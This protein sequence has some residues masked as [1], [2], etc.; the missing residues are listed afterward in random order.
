MAAHGRMDRRGSIMATADGLVDKS[1]RLAEGET[2][3]VTDAR[4]M[5][6]RISRVTLP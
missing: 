1:R 2:A 3:S 6:H 4:P 5:G